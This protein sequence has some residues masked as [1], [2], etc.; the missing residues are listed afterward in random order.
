MHHVTSEK[1]W[2]YDLISI[3]PCPVGLLNGGFTL[4]TQKGFVRLSSTI[5]L[6]DVLLV[7]QFS[8]SLFYV[9]QLTHDL[10]C[11]V[12]FNSSMYAIQDHTM[13]LI[14]TGRKQDGLYFFNR[15]D[16]V[17][18]VSVH[19]ASSDFDFWYRKMCHP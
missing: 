10:N 11:I 3:A 2:M 16:K 1:S 8:C 15:N 13:G 17:K 5:T 7:P 18:L 14:G 19:G 6:T 9:T 4:A 12:Q